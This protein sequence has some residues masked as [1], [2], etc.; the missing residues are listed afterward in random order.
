MSRTSFAKLCGIG[1]I[2][3][4]GIAT[5][6]AWADSKVRLGPLVQVSGASPLPPF[7][8]CGNFAGSVFGGG[9]NYLHA[10]VEP[11]LEVNPTNSKNIVAFYQ[12]DRWSNGGSRAN[13]AASSWD[14]GATWETVIVPGLSQCSG[15]PYERASDPWLSFS[16]NGVLHQMSLLFDIDPPPSAP[17]GFGPSAMAV[18]RSLDGG[19]TWSSPILIQSDTDPRFLNDKNS[20]TADPKNSDLV[21]AV[22]DRLE[23]DPAVGF[24]FKGPAYFA[25]TTDGGV[26]WEPAREIFDPGLNNQVIGSQIV[27]PPNGML[28]NFFDK[29]VSVNP[30]GTFN[31]DPLRLTVIRSDDKGLTWDTTGGGTEIAVIRTFDIYTPDLQLPVRSGSALFDVA[32]D[33]RNG[34]LYA[35]WQDSRFS[36]VDEVAFSQ[37]TDRGRTWSSPIRVNQTP[38]DSLRPLTQQAFLPSVAVSGNGTVVVTHY[39]FRND[40]DIGELADHWMVFCKSKCDEPSHW[41]GEIRLTDTSFDF[42]QAPVARGL[43][44]GDY[45]GLAATRDAYLAF[46]PQSSNADRANGFFRSIAK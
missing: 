15:G 21:Y 26:S 9:I 12:Q 10:E 37:S 33:P 46:F 13:V 3:L 39:D 19:R 2:A 45:L 20:I 8:A 27:V 6:I 4:V 35:V 1:S 25:R 11:W 28:L 30:D 40:A 34:H 38:R 29:I 5:G 22:W 16:P 32:V 7:S 14:G 23:I 41:G 43:F 44:L 17:G 18:S 24:I 42:A 31:S 36:D